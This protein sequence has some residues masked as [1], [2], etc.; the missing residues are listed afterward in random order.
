MWTSA[1]KIKEAV[2]MN[3]KTQKELTNASATVGINWLR[4]KE[5]VKVR[6]L[7]VLYQID[8][9]TNKTRGKR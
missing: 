3:A 4:T 6:L 7:H 5:L 2:I 8:F 1:G 9:K